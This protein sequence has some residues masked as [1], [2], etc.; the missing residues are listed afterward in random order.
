MPKAITRQNPRRPVANFDLAFTCGHRFQRGDW[1]YQMEVVSVGNLCLPTGKIVAADPGSLEGQSLRHFRRTVPPGTYPVDLAVR[2]IGK[3]GEPLHSRSTACMR[4][5][6]QDAPITWW[7]MATLR[8]EK[9]ADLKPF[10]IFGYGVD[11]G[12]GSFADAYGL[13][14]L[15]NRYAHQ[16]KDLYEDFFFPKVYDGN[17]PARGPSSRAMLD[18][19]SGANLVACF[20]GEGDGCYASYWGLDRSGQPVCLVTD[21]DLL[22]HRAYETRELGTLK[23]LLG[24]TRRLE[25]PAGTYRLTIERV[26]QRKL[27]VRESGPAMNTCEV[28]YF[29]RGEPFDWRTGSYDYRTRGRTSHLQ[30]GR[31][32]PDD[33]VVAVRYLD[34]LEPL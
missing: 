21:F 20:S 25:L 24:R 32:V 17:D 1:H 11:A 7:E 26:G 34:R 18:K 13:A 33:V 2:H 6:F 22:T 10:K 23:E 9:F 4:V 29:R 19:A 15:V 30:F 27:I 5:R 16:D 14:V 31:V 8:G 12:M 3:V 28:T